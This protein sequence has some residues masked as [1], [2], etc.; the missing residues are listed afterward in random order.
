MQIDKQVIDEVNV[1]LKMTLEKADYQERVD[2]KLKEYRKKA[3]IPGFRPGYVPASL[4][5]KRFG[6]AILV[7]E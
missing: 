4:I 1:V 3:N 5:K 7:E 6:K 2:K